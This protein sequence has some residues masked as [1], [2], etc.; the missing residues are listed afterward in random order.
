MEIKIPEVGESIYEATI[1]KWHKQEGDSVAKEDLLCEVETDKITL[2]IHAEAAGTLSLKA[3]E[4]ETVR[5]GAVIAILAE[6]AGNAAEASPPPEKTKP[7]KAAAEKSVKK[8]AK[9]EPKPTAK[10][11]AAAKPAVVP[12]PAPAAQTPPA[13]PAKTTSAPE[14]D[15]RTTRKAMSPI[16]RKIAER[17]LAVRQQT[18]MATT[19]N[20]ADLSR[21]MDLRRRH[22]DSFKARHGVKL[23]IM[24]FFIKACAEALKEFPEVNAR[25]DG[26]DIVYQHFYD[27]GIAVSA[28]KGLLVP[29]I[30]DADHKDF[31]ELE[32]TI[33][34][35]AE[36][37]AASRIELSEL[38]GG[39]FSISNGGTY[40]SLL[41]T[42]LLNPPQSAI[43]GMHA[44]QERPVV[45]DGAVVI[46]PMMNLALSYD[47]RLIDGRQ[48]VEFLM[49]VKTLVEEPE[50]MLL[51]L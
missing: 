50:E 27:I 35:F 7:P 14:S 19:F 20:E 39:T 49:R 21:I 11:A 41:S 5:V 46:R 38:E 28:A 3:A 24:S 17:L 44:I 42:P 37:A 2:E 26:N 8:P 12:P 31:S 40:G 30:R 33:G 34:D 16:R 51:E 36:R 9:D 10:P 22:R 47:H 4:G 48:A 15:Q 45:R 29:V 6:S 32:Q 25:I 18:A 43:L 13:A 1:A 23:G